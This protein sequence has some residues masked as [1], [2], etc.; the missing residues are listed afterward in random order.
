M[1]DL[2]TLLEAMAVLSIIHGW[3]QNELDN[4]GRQEEGEHI[5]RLR[6]T[7]LYVFAHTN[8]LFPRFCLRLA[9][10]FPEAVLGSFRER[11][12]RVLS[13]VFRAVV[14]N[15]STTTVV[16]SSLQSDRAFAPPNKPDTC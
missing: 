12:P 7:I 5:E 16:W 15:V 4:V 3:N 11:G 13:L 2:L 8:C 9:L 1:A 10:C 14:F 6:C